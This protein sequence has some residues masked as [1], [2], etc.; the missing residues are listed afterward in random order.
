ME[1]TTLL[2]I[3]QTEM[4]KDYLER[5]SRSE[6][7]VKMDYLCKHRVFSQLQMIT[8]CKLAKETIHSKCTVG[9][10]I[11]KKGDFSDG[12][13]IIIRGT[14]TIVYKDAQK[15]ETQS[16]KNKYVA[17]NGEMGSQTSKLLKF[18]LSKLESQIQSKSRPMSKEQNQDNMKRRTTLT[19]RSSK[20]LPNTDSRSQLG[21]GNKTGT[22]RTQSPQSKSPSDRGRAAT[23][24]QKAGNFISEKLKPDQIFGGYFF[25][26]DFSNEMLQPKFY[27]NRCEYSI[28]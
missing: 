14:V 22:E 7:Y 10:Y 27:K 28:V 11:I 8:A 2:S 4:M 12:L 21:G 19:S 17:N 25:W 26:R 6:F 20:F 5:V 15:E 1:D 3:E 9:D 24:F 13:Y 18:A 23:D 16:T